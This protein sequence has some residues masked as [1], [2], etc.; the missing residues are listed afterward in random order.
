MSHNGPEDPSAL[1]WQNVHIS[2]R[3]FEGEEITPFT[4]RRYKDHFWDIDNLHQFVIDWV[5]RFGFGG[6]YQYRMPLAVDHALITALIERWRS[7][8]HIF[9]LPIGET[10][11]TLQDVQVLCGLPAHGLPFTGNSCSK[12]G[13]QDLCDEL[14]GFSSHQCEMKENGLHV[15]ALVHKMVLESLQDGLHPEVYIQRAHMIVLILLGALILPDGSRCKVPLIW[16]TVLQNVGDVPM[17]S[18]PN[19]TLATLYHNLC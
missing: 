1:L 14:L 10:T 4:I 13:W 7:E 9:H 18:W 8:T 19:V 2:L 17:Y 16:L 5:Q 12:Q 3:A 6:V 11:I 15:S